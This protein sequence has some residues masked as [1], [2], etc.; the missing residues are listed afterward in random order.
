[1]ALF[2][3]ILC[4]YWYLYPFKTIEFKQPHL[5]QN[6]DNEVERGDRLRYLVDYCKY[7][8]I[9]PEVTK[10][11][12]DGVI[13]ETPKSTGVVEKGCGMV[14]SDVYV[15]K[16]IPEGTYTLKIVS[17]YKLNPLRTIDVVSLTEKFTVK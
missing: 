14:V 2:L 1:M 9:Q 15:P 4:S 6:L 17:R 3:I 11:F 8:N 12:I 13:Y 16:A 10:Y 7:T 5:I